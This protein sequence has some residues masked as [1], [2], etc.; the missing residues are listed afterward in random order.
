MSDD[1]VALVDRHEGGGKHDCVERNVVLGHE[2]VHLHLSL[3]LGRPPLRP[4]LCVAL[5]DAH[6][7]YRRVEPHVEHLSGQTVVL[8]RQ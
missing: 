8:E 1:C 2:L 5:G 3:G 4:L 7:P 6:V